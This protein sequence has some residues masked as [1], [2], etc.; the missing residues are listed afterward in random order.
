MSLMRCVY[1]RETGSESWVMQRHCCIAAFDAT[2]GRL[3]RTVLALRAV[4]PY[5]ESRVED[6]EAAAE[7]GDED[8]DAPKAVTAR[9]ILIESERIA[10][11][12]P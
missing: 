10:E 7:A 12:Q 6:L 3:E 4:L 9:R 2:Q 1:C 8:D 5:A 11:A